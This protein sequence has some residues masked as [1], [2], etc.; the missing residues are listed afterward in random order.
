MLRSRIA[1]TPGNSV[2]ARRMLERRARNPDTDVQKH[3]NEFVNAYYGKAAPKMLAYLDTIH[4]PVREQGKHI[5]IFDKPT[6][7]YLS[8]DVMNAAEKILDGAELLAE[9]DEVRFRV[10]V[11]RLPVWYVKIATDRVTGDARKDLARR[12]VVIARKAGVSHLS[13]SKS[14]DEWA[15]KLG[16]E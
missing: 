4:R 11:A 13:E 1:D 7:S 2:G 15:K 5:H 6:S 10:Q 9:N 16:V 3:I 14:L 12:F 8:E